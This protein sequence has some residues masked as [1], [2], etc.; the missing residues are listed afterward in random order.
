M[1]ENRII[2]WLTRMRIMAN[3]GKEWLKLV[4]RRR[5]WPYIKPALGQRLVFVGIL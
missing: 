3:F 4:H 1:Y 2:G 5:R